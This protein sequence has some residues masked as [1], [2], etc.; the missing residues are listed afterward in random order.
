MT[1][2]VLAEAG[3]FVYAGMRD[4]AES[5]REAAEALRE[6][7]AASPLALNAVPMDVTDDRVVRAAVD[8]IIG[9]R[10]HLPGAHGRNHSPHA[11]WRQVVASD[12][13]RRDAHPMGPE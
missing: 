11:Q 4:V 9:D 13:G 2:R 1:A 3:H 10:G 6:H 5:D 12:H 7:A 8:R